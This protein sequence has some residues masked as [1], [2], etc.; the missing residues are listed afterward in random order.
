M[1]PSIQMFCSTEAPRK[2][3]PDFVALGMVYFV[4]SNGV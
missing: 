1:A 3:K 2:Q 4:T